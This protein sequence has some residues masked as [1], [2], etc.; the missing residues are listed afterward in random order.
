MVQGNRKGEPVLGG[1][2]CFPSKITQ[3]ETAELTWSHSYKRCVE[4]C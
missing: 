2:L 4:G 1:A 3:E